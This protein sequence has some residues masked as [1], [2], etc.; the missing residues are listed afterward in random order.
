M[1]AR[2]AANADPIDLDAR[3]LRVISHKETQRH[4]SE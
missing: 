4:L 3:L 1:R 2:T